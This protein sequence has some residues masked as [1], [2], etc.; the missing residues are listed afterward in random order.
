MKGFRRGLAAL[1][2]VIVVLVT[3]LIRNRPGRAKIYW[4]LAVF[5]LAGLAD[6][7]S[8]F[9]FDKYEYV[10]WLYFSM[11]L[12]AAACAGML[13]TWKKQKGLLPAGLICGATALLLLAYASTDWNNVEITPE[14]DLIR[15]L[16]LYGTMAVEL[17]CIGLT[18]YLNLKEAKKAD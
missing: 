13:W 4:C 2:T 18:I 9:V 3:L 7:A 5:V 16:I 6:M 15:F 17:F 11:P 1:L 8:E 12:A 14:L 10:H